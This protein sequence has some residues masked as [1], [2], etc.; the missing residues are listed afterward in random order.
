M[1][2]L[3]CL[4]FSLT[5]KLADDEVIVSGA[6]WPKVKPD[7]GHP[8]ELNAAKATEP[9]ATDTTAPRP[10]RLTMYVSAADNDGRD[11]SVPVTAAAEELTLRVAAVNEAS[12]SSLQAIETF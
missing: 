7:A 9:S 5:G 12:E 1:I 10:P 8:M 4:C 2:S 3:Y 6:F 11:D